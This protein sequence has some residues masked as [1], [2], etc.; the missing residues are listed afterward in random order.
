MSDENCAPVAVVMDNGSGMFKAGFAGNDAPCAV[1]SSIVGRP[2]QQG[3]VG[4]RD[5]YVGDEAQS[6]RGIL[7]WQYPIEH[8]IVTNWD[9]MET[10]WHHTFYN[11][12][13][14]KPTEYAVLLTEV[15]LNPKENREKM[16]EVMFEKF[17]IPATYVANPAC[18]GITREQLTL[19]HHLTAFSI[20]RSPIFGDK[21]QWD[22]WLLEAGYKRWACLN[23]MIIIEITDAKIG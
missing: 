10:I 3:I 18:A 5:A 11:E 17:G 23:N 9:D 14:V 15:A 6:K 1:F 16:V 19:Q 2:R 7:T 8:G 21:K 22:G 13:K 4:Q 20:K 12:L